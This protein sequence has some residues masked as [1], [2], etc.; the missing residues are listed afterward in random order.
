MNR[1][2]ETVMCKYYATSNHHNDVTA[3]IKVTW[4]F[5][6]RFAAFTFGKRIKREDLQNLEY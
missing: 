5:N 3:R 2:L 6:D 4:L 1:P